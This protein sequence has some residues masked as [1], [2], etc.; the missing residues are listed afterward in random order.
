MTCTGFSLYISEYRS[1]SDYLLLVVQNTGIAIDLSKLAISIHLQR[2]LIIKLF[3]RL[4]G[5]SFR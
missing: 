3:R 5:A 2:A 1:T 4:N